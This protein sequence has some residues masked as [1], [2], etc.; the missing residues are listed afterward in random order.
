MLKKRR[1]PQFISFF[2]N[3]YRYEHVMIINLYIASHITYDR[4]VY[5][6]IILGFYACL[7]EAY[8]FPL[9]SLN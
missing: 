7:K 4:H 3:K 2:E 5:E 8:G 6:C 9:L 1:P